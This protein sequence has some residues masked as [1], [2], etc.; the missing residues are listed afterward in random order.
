MLIKLSDTQWVDS[1]F[2]RRLFVQQFNDNENIIYKLAADL[3]DKTVYGV[4][5]T[6]FHEACDWLNCFAQGISEATRHEK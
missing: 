4:A 2:V 6:N 5:F 3:G 1:R